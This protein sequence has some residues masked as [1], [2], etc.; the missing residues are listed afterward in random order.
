MSS[1]VDIPP[2]MSSDV[3]LQDAAYLEP[4]QT[5]RGQ[6]AP[7]DAAYLEPCQTDRGQPAPSDAAYLEPCQTDR[8]QPA[9]SDAAYL[10]LCQTDRG[11]PAPSDAA[12][13]EPCQT[14]RGQPAPSDAAYL[15]LCQTDRGQP[16]PSVCPLMQ[17]T[18]SRVRLTEV[19]PHLVCVLCHGYFIDAT[20][21]AECP[22]SFCRSCIVLYL[23]T[24][25]Y[26]PICEVQIH[27]TKPHLNLKPDKTLQDIVYKLVPGLYHE[28]M[29]R[30]K[31]FYAK[32]PNRDL[33]LSPEARGVGVERIIYSPEDQIS[34]SLEYYD[35]SDKTE[36]EGHRLRK[37][38]RVSNRSDREREE[39]APT[40]PGTQPVVPLQKPTPDSNGLKRYLQCPAVVTMRHLKKFLRLK[41]G[42]SPS[43]T[44]EILYRRESLP[45]SYSLMDI[46]YIYTWKR[47]GPMR[48]YYRIHVPTTLRTILP[49]L[50]PSSEPIRDLGPPKRHPGSELLDAV[51][52]R[53]KPID[54]PRDPTLDPPQLEEKPHKKGVE[55]TA[56][57]TDELKTSVTK[58]EKDRIKMSPEESNAVNQLLALSSG[59]IP[60]A[61]SSKPK[62]TS[63]PVS[64]ILTT[65]TESGVVTTP[66]VA[67][68]VSVTP[69]APSITTSVTEAPTK[70]TTS[71]GNV[72]KVPQSMTKR[73]V[74]NGGK[75]VAAKNKQSNAK[76]GGKLG[77]KSRVNGKLVNGD[78]T[79]DRYT[80]PLGLGGMQGGRLPPGSPR[81]PPN[82]DKIMKTK[83]MPPAGLLMSRLPEVTVSQN[84]SPS[85]QRVAQKTQVPQ[86]SSSQPQS[87]HNQNQNRPVL[88]ANGNKTASPNGQ[89]PH[90]KETN[91]LEQIV[92]NCLKKETTQKKETEA[93]CEANG[94]KRNGTLSANGSESARAAS[95]IRPPDH[96]GVDRVDS[97]AVGTSI[98]KRKLNDNPLNKQAAPEGLGDAKKRRLVTPDV[99]IE[100]TT[101]PSKD[102]Q[103]ER[104]PS[105]LST[106]TKRFLH[107]IQRTSMKKIDSEI[108]TN[109]LEQMCAST[110]KIEK[111]PAPPSRSAPAPKTAVNGTEKTKPIDSTEFSSDE[112][113]LFIDIRNK[114]E[115]LKR[116]NPEPVSIAIERVSEDPNAKTDSVQS[117]PSTD[118]EATTTS[119]TP[120]VSNTTTNTDVT[121]KPSGTHKKLPRLIEINAPPR[122]KVP[123]L[124]SDPKQKTGVKMTTVRKEVPIGKEGP[125]VR[126]DSNGALDLSAGMSPPSKTGSKS[127]LPRTL[128]S[129]KSPTPSALSPLLAMSSFPLPETKASPI[130]I[131]NIKPK[132]SPNPRPSSLSS[133]SP[134]PPA[135]P[136]AASEVFPSAAAYQQLYRHQMELQS[137]FLASQVNNNNWSRENPLTPKKFEDWM[138]N[139]M[140]LPHHPLMFPS[141]LSPESGRK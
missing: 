50:K 112:D 46:A 129:E 9:P 92:Q 86:V 22:H 47:N 17:H 64:S 32:Y 124:I 45:D 111:V 94:M 52:L 49:P 15:E 76:V 36:A 97:A 123:S 3:C 104:K 140:N 12:Y 138:R 28:E 103:K 108:K 6:P 121:P 122:P 109:K 40:R 137:R 14:D 120:P 114:C 135:E 83:Y 11:Q 139:V 107:D 85:E 20:T 29:R 60:V 38:E 100:L 10:E 106:L 21:M 18:W 44:V 125:Q 105:D 39:W 136:R 98:L 30:R 132:T 131:P 78:N 26:C 73:F 2:L 133:S 118:T 4:C 68:T 95:S 62:E 101:H 66:A 59:Q 89:P 41:Y 33:Y 79:V 74:L 5:D 130:R 128:S 23:E 63:E 7:S 69:G 81:P 75:L 34:L 48:F 42:L 67:A 141:Q 93:R 116:K 13:L 55:E 96:A 35:E 88:N 37:K 113:Q 25:A 72:F 110:V 8:G 70:S 71:N 91:R 84:K 77:E 61:N 82:S 31:E 1:S 87:K 16:A 119:S 19:N 58:E 54:P 117:P 43:C 24:K 102:K 65:P 134:S 99:S 27:K 56:K 57:P 53:P 115:A 127:P 51:G 126:R 80:N 90:R